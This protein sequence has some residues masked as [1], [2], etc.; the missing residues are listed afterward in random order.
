MVPGAIGGVEVHRKHHN[1][2]DLIK[3]AKA[4]CHFCVKIVDDVKGSPGMLTELLDEYDQDPIYARSQITI[5]VHSN[6]GYTYLGGR[7]VYA[8]TVHKEIREKPV[9][10]A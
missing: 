8:V 7:N 10:R 6:R 4:G 3:S 1:I 5:K 9:P 2:N